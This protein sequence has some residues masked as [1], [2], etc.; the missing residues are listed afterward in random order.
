MTSCRCWGSFGLPCLVVASILRVF[1]AYRDG[2]S[3]CHGVC[4]ALQVFPGGH[5]V[6]GLPPVSSVLPPLFLASVFF[7]VFYVFEMSFFFFCRV[8][9]RSALFFLLVG[10]PFPVMFF[11]NLRP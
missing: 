7:V 2:S 8:A 5:Q 11:Y 3:H 6:D 10:I 4:Y 1:F 9:H